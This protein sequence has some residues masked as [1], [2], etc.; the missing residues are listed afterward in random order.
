MRV[1]FVSFLILAASGCDHNLDLLPTPNTEFR[2]HELG[3]R[4][5]NLSKVPMDEGDWRMKLDTIS[6]A[7][8]SLREHCPEFRDSAFDKTMLRGIPLVVAP[9]QKIAV[10]SGPADAFWRVNMFYW[11]FFGKPRAIFIRR[12]KWE[13]QS[14]LRHEWIHAYLYFIGEPS[15]KGYSHSHPLFE[16]C[17]YL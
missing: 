14:N 5:Y 9:P 3:M 12:D 13:D 2:D 15:Q 8:V 16:R 4:V 11:F 17:E 10:S 7:Y 6:S 1:A